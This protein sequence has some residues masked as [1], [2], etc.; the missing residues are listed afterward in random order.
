MKK[1]VTILLAGILLLSSMPMAALAEGFTQVVPETGYEIAVPQIDADADVKQVLEDMGIIMPDGA[2]TDE[3]DWEA[4]Y[5]AQLRQEKVDMGMPYPDGINVSLNGAFL[6]LDGVA[7]T[8]VERRTMVPLRAFLE[9]VGATVN[10]QDGDITAKLPDGDSLELAV[11]S[12]ELIHNV[13]DK[14]NTAEMGVAP[15]VE[16]G[17]VYIPIRFVAEALGLDLLWDEDYQVIHLTDWDAIAAQID[18]DFTSLNALLTAQRGSFDP[19]KTYDLRMNG[20]FSGSLYAEN[21]VDTATMT[22][23]LTGLISGKAGDFSYGIKLDRGGMKNTVFAGVAES[24]GMLGIEQADTEQVLNSLADFRLDLRGDLE[25]GRV[26]F[27]GNNLSK[28]PESPLPDNTWLGLEEIPSGIDLAALT[29]ESESLT[30]GR[31]MVQGPSARGY[32][33]GGVAP[34]VQALD[35]AADLALVLGDENF[36][37][38][39]S[40]GVT[41]YTTAMDAEKLL[42]GMD[43]EAVGELFDMLDGVIPGFDWLLTFRLKDGALLDGKL[44]A[45]VR[46]GGSNPTAVAI[47]LFVT[48]ETLNGVL[49]AKATYGGKCEFKLDASVK[50]T[51]R[52][53]LNAPAA[54]EKVESLSDYTGY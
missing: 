47:T 38:K 1:C 6:A 9:G 20:K 36:T 48:P 19:D 23:T 39:E 26:W 51:T 12:T 4:E 22:A 8:V 11:G 16:D 15:Y 50:E 31:L 28:L 40:G 52:T 34:C 3:Y 29:E 25:S 49:T 13:G 42:T 2:Y 17:R 27:R 30:V 37:V 45:N 46:G 35:T 21:R 32:V 53:V 7:P 54:G 14:I 33:Y 5:A 10:Y 24:M 44:T 18:K 43:G 41:T